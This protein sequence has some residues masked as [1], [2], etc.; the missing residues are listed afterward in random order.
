MGGEREDR[1]RVDG[2]LRLGPGAGVGGEQ[3]VVVDDDPVVDADDRPVPDGMV[4][5]VD[6]RVA[7]RV[8]ADV[9]E[10]LVRGLRHR[11]A[12]EDAGVRCL[13][14]VGY[15]WPGARYA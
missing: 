6:R 14:T 8:V 9:H 13:T 12:L 1:F 4:V 10:E 7:L 11:D 5:G 2:H 15:V 3:L